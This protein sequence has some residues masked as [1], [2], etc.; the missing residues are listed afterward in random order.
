MCLTQEMPPLKFGC[1]SVIKGDRLGQHVIPKP[2]DVTAPDAATLHLATPMAQQAKLEL[3][4]E[5]KELWRNLHTGQWRAPEEDVNLSCM[6]TQSGHDP[7]PPSILLRFC[8][9][10]PESVG[11]KGLQAKGL[12]QASLT[13]LGGALC[14]AASCST[15]CLELL[16]SPCTFGGTKVKS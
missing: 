10:R 15:V 11:A 7:D 5:T 3:P 1:P 4:E 6:K 2:Q 9:S 13:Y 12:E 14:R 8:G 16:K